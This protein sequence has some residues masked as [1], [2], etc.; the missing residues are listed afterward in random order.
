MGFPSNDTTLLDEAFKSLRSTASQVKVSSINIRAGSISGPQSAVVIVNHMKA[1]KNY[2]AKLSATLNSVDVPSLVAY[3]QQQR[4][5]QGNISTEYTA[6][7]TAINDT[8]V[9][10]AS[11]IAKTGDNR[12]QI[13]YI[14]AQGNTA[15]FFY[16]S[17]QLQP[18][19]DTLD[20]LIATIS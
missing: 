14:D 5:N 15:D 9:W 10:I 3:A 18:F 19:R 11:N 7:V 17:G 6:M 4:G 16:T 2:A 1:L 12:L 8:V 20:A 13:E